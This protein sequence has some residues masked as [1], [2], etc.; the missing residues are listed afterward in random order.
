MTI[1]E[2][3]AKLDDY[4]GALAQSVEKLRIERDRG[5]LHQDEQMDLLADL[6]RAFETR[7]IRPWRAKAVGTGVAAVAMLAVA[8]F[9]PADLP[10]AAVGRLGALGLALLAM[11]LVAFDLWTIRKQHHQMDPWFNRAEAAVLKSGNLFDVS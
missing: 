10:H 11:L 5:A 7:L 9:L 2:L 4:S 1:L 8:G 3:A 6:R